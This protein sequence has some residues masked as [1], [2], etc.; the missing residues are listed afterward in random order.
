MEPILVERR[1]GR[2]GLVTLN[3]PEKLNALNSEL[4]DQLEAALQELDADESVGAIVITG[5][6]DARFFG[7]RRHGR[8]DRRAGDGAARSP[9]VSA[10]AVVRAVSPSRRSPRFAAT[11]SAAARCWPSSATSASAATTRGSS[12]TAPVTV[13]RRAAPCLPRIVGDRQGQRAA[14]HR[15]RDLG[16]RGAAH[17]PA[18]SASC[19]PRQVVEAAVAM[20][21]RIAA[22]SPVAIRALKEIIELALPI[23]AALEQ[24]RL[25][26]PRHR[27]FLGQRVRFRT[28][29]SGS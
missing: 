4:V 2:V 12:S 11:A 3:R 19:R 13:A 25:R 5:A 15:R 16:G 29:P 8:A 7:R 27:S 18:Q 1:R 23:E 20:G 24:E 9:R 21:E 14:L 17:R 28:P 26:Q 10:S 6:G 22:N